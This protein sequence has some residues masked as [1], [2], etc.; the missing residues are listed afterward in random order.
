VTSEI[1]SGIPGGVGL[2]V[3]LNCAQLRAAPDP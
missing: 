2:G 3:S 1:R